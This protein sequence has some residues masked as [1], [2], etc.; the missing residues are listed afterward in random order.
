M[1][2]TSLKN[3]SIVEHRLYIN[4]DFVCLK[5]EVSKLISSIAKPNSVI[6]F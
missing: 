2:C 4:D 6:C 1:V 5:S 3:V